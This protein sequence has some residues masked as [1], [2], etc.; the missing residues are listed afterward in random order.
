MGLT[1]PGKGYVSI[2]TDDLRP[3]AGSQGWSYASMRFDPQ[4]D[5]R[6]VALVRDDG[7][8]AEFTVPEF[9]NEPLDLRAIAQIVI[10]SCE[11][12]Q[13]RQGVGG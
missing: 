5:S 2:V 13:N 10:A 4:Q 9:V 1:R 6:T 3:V 11:R 7:T 12:W 8:Q